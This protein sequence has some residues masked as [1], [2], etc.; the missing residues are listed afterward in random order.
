MNCTKLLSLFCFIILSAQLQGQFKEPNY[1]NKIWICINGNCVNGEGTIAD[2]SFQEHKITGVFKDGLLE[3]KGKW[4][5]ET[6]FPVR[7][8]YFEGEFSGGYRTQGKWWDNNGNTYTGGWKNGLMHG[9]G[10]YITNHSTANGVWEAGVLAEGIFE[11]K[12]G[13]KMSIVPDK[14]GKT[15]T[16]ITYIN[17]DFFEGNVREKMKEGFGIMKYNNME[18]YEGEWKYDNKH[19]KG[20]QRWPNGDKY[21]GQW[22]RNFRSGQG[23]MFWSKDS[24]E[25]TGGWV[26]DKPEGKGIF[27]FQKRGKITGVD[28]GYYHKGVK[29]CADAQTYESFKEGI[30]QKKE[31]EM[32]VFKKARADYNAFLASEFKVETDIENCV[33]Y[34]IS[35]TSMNVFGGASKDSYVILY[36]VNDKSKE[37]T[38]EQ[39]EKMAEI[40]FQKRGTSGYSHLQKIVNK[41]CSCQSIISEIKKNFPV[42]QTLQ[43]E[44]N[45]TTPIENK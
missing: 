10:V 34:V 2:K 5:Y 36:Q 9:V 43:Y 44:I 15:T 8:F 12:N 26:L 20:M 38:T 35:K 3:G 32:E 40:D 16:K 22:S 29:V 7:N 13:L 45:Y 31:S 11:E 17:N 30:R 41:G 18:V 37:A 28:S 1:N 33:T 24:T 4:V 42:M 6:S 27:T 14:E 25:Y 39:I 23:K 21:D 19:G